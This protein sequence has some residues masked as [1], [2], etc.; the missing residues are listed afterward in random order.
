MLLIGAGFEEIEP[1]PGIQLFQTVSDPAFQL[2]EEQ[3]I[4]QLLAV[5][6][7]VCLTKI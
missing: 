1:V 3:L 5:G 2:Q 7:V 4:D 6:H